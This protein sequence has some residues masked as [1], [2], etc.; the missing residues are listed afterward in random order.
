MA[1]P[2]DS[3]SFPRKLAST[4]AFIG[5]MVANLAIALFGTAILD[6]AIGKAVR[7]SSLSAVLLKEWILSIAIALS[8]GF[9]ITRQWN[10]RAARWT[11]A[12][13]SL[14][15]VLGIVA[16]I[17]AGGVLSQISGSA[18]QAGVANPLCRGWFIFTIPFV[19]SSA[20]SVGAALQEQLR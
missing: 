18:C 4:P 12:L 9:G 17:G 2:D 6:A 16:A 7:P 19:R 14:R 20:Y 15:F 5:W 11:W 3:S 1:L 13:P 8:L 10:N